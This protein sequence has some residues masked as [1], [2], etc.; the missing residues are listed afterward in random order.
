M[1]IAT[2]K[3]TARREA[4]AVRTHVQ[5]VGA[6]RARVVRVLGMREES[7]HQLPLEPLGLRMVAAAANGEPFDDA[8]SAGSRER[9]GSCNR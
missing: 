3:E 8:E 2:V 9:R 1:I 7:D 6:R 5:R 4:E